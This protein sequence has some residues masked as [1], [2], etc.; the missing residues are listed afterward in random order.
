MA[1]PLRAAF[2]SASRFVARN[3]FTMMKMARHA[4]GMRMAIPLDALRWFVSNTPPGKSAPQDVTITTDPPAIT[5]GASLDLMDTP[6]RATASIR[7]D[8]LRIHPDELRLQL[9]LSNVSLKLLADSSTPVAGLIKSGAL[10]LSKP[11]NLANFMPKK[12]AVLVEAHDDVI[13]LDLMKSPAIAGNF[14]LRRVLQR[15]T[16]VVN[17][18][19]LRTE[20]DFLI[21]GLRATPL[22]FPRALNPASA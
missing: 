22:G 7:V 19:A 1:L 13:V 2:R 10:D 20:G 3:P 15:L 6:V 18:A 9:H 8:E 17:V 21:V 5:L 16:P 11:G 4:L 14:K 12:P